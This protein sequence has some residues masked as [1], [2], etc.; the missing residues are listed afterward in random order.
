MGFVST[1]LGI[2]G[3]AIGLPIG[4]ILGFFLF[5]YSKPKEIKVCPFP[6]LVN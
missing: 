2:V 3:F 6:V 5:V 1:F 4:L